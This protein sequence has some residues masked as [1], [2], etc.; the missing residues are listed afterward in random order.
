[1]VVCVRRDADQWCVPLV[2]SWSVEDSA[3]AREAR[4]TR[5]YSLSPCGYRATLHKCGSAGVTVKVSAGEAELV[6]RPLVP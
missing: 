4:L 2:S 3:P 5:D 1:M 6:R